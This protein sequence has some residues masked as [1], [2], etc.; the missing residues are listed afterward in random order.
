[1]FRSLPSIESPYNV[2]MASCRI[3]LVED[4][5]IVAA[6]LQSSLQRA[7]HHVVGTAEDFAEAL[8]LAEIASPDIVLM[9]IKLRGSRDGIAA[10]AVIRERWQI[11]VVFLTANADE[12]TLELARS[13][14][15][16][17]FLTKPFRNE[18]L[19]ETI[20]IAIGQNQSAQALF[21]SH[22]WLTTVL[23]SLSDAVIAADEKGCVRYLNPAAEALTGWTPAEADGQA[24][25]D[26]YPLTLLNG[27][28]L[29]E[30][31]L[32]RALRLGQFQGKDRVYLTSKTGR[33]FLIEDS[34]TPIREKE[35][36]VGAVT[37]FMDVTERLAKERAQELEKDRLEEQAL[38]A[39]QAL[40]E[41]R[42]E[43]RALAGN[44]INTQELERR[45]IARELHDDLGQRAALLGVS[46]DNA[47]QQSRMDGETAEAL[48][49]QIH[50]VS[51]GL[52]EVSHRL[53][54]SIIA[55]LGFVAALQ[56][57]VEQ[58]RAAGR[59]VTLEEEAAQVSLPL[60]LATPLYRIAQEALHNAA[61][62]APAA[63]VSISLTATSKDILLRVQDDGPGFSLAE[64]RIRGGLGL[65]SMQE[66]A[67]LV[68]GNLLLTTE[69]GQGTVLLARVPI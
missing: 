60:D 27:Q 61:K 65:V 54:P 43:L 15:P 63:A 44:L 9:D 57:L 68:G 26:V 69:P 4:E 36:I 52:R 7:G 33:R 37:I 50:E 48:R 45:R 34:A 3:L 17:G 66:R 55:D 56:N 18:E 23:D 39:T 35:R 21:A 53:H 1:M 24:I 14:G 2:T 20:R 11:P 16:F 64:A 42:A 49:S 22:Q 5:L 12:R 47:L 67:R 8:H 28:G 25:E 41:T 19:L 29:E 51:T 10:A 59:A 38:I 46:I 58:E 62:H 30:C 31:L 32:R 6:D 13:V 40:G